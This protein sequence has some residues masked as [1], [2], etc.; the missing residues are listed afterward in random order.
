MN[1]DQTAHISEYIK[2]TEYIMHAN[3][4][5]TLIALDMQVTNAQAGTG[6]AGHREIPSGPVAIKQ[7]YINNLMIFAKTFDN[8]GRSD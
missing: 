5:N 1:N 6:P 3:V 7:Y 8:A 2:N 4:Q